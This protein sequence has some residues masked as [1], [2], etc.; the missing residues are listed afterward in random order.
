VPRP[1]EPSA[2]GTIF[3]VDDDVSVREALGSLLRSAGFTVQLFASAGEFTARPKTDSPSCL[4]LDVQLPDLDGLA[5]QQQLL[6]EDA[7]IPIV[8]ITA[9]GD[10]PMS[11]RAMKSGAVEFLTK[12]FVE[13]DLLESIRQA[14]ARATDERSRQ[15]SIAA[16][17]SR[18]ALLTPRERE[19]MALVVSGLLNKQAAAD[20]GTS[21]ITVKVHRGQVMRKMEA[22]SLADLVRMAERLGISPDPPS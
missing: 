11:V 7:A 17:R 16:L 22:K 14:I 4:V 15:A 9:H 13:A 5:L 6:A 21:E 10:I 20:L 8:F 12:P 2:R 1:P 19:V 3:V 18:Y